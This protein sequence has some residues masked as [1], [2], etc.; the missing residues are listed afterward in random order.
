L[1]KSLDAH[2]MQKNGAAEP[3]RRISKLHN[4]NNA[5]MIAGAIMLVVGTIVSAYLGSVFV[6]DY[7]SAAHP[8]PGY[9]IISP[10]DTQIA[11]IFIAITGLG[12]T[13]WG[14]GGTQW[15]KP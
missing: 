6:H 8:Y 11:F 7:T 12:L 14:L 10:L 2:E 3:M 9:G 15:A 13:V 4:K 5:M 1:T